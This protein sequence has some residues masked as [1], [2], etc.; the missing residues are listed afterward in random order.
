V[1]R[2]ATAPPIFE[3]GRV[4]RDLGVAAPKGAFGAFLAGGSRPGPRSQGAAPPVLSPRR[5]PARRP[6][7]TRL[8]TPQTP[9][10]GGQA[11]AEGKT[12]HTSPIQD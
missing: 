7:R 4:R 9:V 8:G 6:S 11:R 1:A 3:A 10:S 5:T 2:P 12:A